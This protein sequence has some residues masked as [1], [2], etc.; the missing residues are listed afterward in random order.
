MTTVEQ[1]STTTMKMEVT[2]VRPFEGTAKATLVG[3]PRTATAD[4]LEFNKDTK[5]LTFTIKTTGETPAASNKNIFC[6]AEI[7]SPNGTI[8]QTLAS[9]GVL[10]VDKPRLAQQ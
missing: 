6:T 5:S 7:P 4:P 9:G 3:L 8:P 1:G 2:H 10:R